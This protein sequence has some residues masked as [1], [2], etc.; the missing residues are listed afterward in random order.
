[1]SD[2]DK[3]VQVM[4]KHIYAD[5]ATH[6]TLRND[7][8]RICS[9]E[10]GTFKEVHDIRLASSLLVETVLVLL[11]TDGPSENDLVLAGREPVI[12]VVKDDFD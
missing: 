12:R 3:V 1:M 11:Q 2:L 10:S 6:A 5:A 8:I 7:V 9:A 4:C